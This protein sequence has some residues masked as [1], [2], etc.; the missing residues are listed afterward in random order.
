MTY[1]FKYEIKFTKIVINLKQR[2]WEEEGTRVAW[3]LASSLRAGE[4]NL[5]VVQTTSWTTLSEVVVLISQCSSS[6]RTKELWEIKDSRT[7]G[8]VEAFNKSSG[9]RETSN[10]KWSKVPW[11]GNSHFYRRTREESST[12]RLECSRT[13]SCRH[14]QSLEETRDLN[15]MHWQDKTS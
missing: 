12:S 5:T 3:P 2:Q 8:L 11:M 10:S 13:H 7:E 14:R 1:S 4:V 15:L 9:T 6:K